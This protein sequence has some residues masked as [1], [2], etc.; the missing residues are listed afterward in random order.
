MTG[1]I[2]A[3]GFLVLGVAGLAAGVLLRKKLSRVWMASFCVAGVLLA[4]LGGALGVGQWNQTR[5]ERTWSYLALC[6]LEQGQTEQAAQYLLKTDRQDLETTA[7]QLLLER[8]RGNDTIARL[9]ADTLNNLART[10]SEKNLCSMVS[11]VAAGDYEAV[12]TAAALLREQSA[13]T[14]AAR[15]QADRRF[16]AETGVWLGDPEDPTAYDQELPEAER[17]RQQVDQALNNGSN[18][19]A[20]ENAAQLV[21]LA[22]SADNRLLLASAVAESVYSGDYLDASCFAAD[23]QEPDESATAEREKLAGQIEKLESQQAQL[24]RKGPAVCPAGGTAGRERQPIRPAGAEL[25]R[26]HPQ[27]GGGDRAR[28]AAVCHAGLRAGS[29]SAAER[30]RF[31]A[32]PPEPLQQ[33]DQRAERRAP[34][35]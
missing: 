33:P 5:E 25:H 30:G 27:P 23:G 34:R 18:R 28:P 2:M 7:A 8:L 32:V 26:G 21:Q 29:G 6:Y 14:G 17:L 13:L 20:V 1:W 16:A 24:R 12:R 10:D 11:G 31:A 35:L 4:V 22:P 19:W 15:T 3:I 9:R